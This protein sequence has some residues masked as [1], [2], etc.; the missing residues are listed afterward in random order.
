MIVRRPEMRDE[1]AELLAKLTQYD[2]A[3]DE[4]ELLGRR[5]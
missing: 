4:D 2:L 1:L 3:K 5:K